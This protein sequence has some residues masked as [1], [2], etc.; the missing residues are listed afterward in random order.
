MNSN[1]NLEAAVGVLGFLGTGFCL[2]VASLLAVYSFARGKRERAANVL[3]ASFGGVALYLVLLLAFS[4]AS[5]EKQLARGEEKYFCEID[6]HLAY[7]VLNVRRTKTLGL[8]PDAI[9]AEGI[10]YVVTV[11]TRFDET[12]ITPRRGNFPL[13]PNSRVARVFDEEGRGYELAR[14]SG[15]PLTTPLRPGES[16]T[17]ELIFDLPADARNPRL[18]INETNFV[19]HFIVGHE[20]SPL[21]EKTEFR[22]EPSEGQSAGVAPTAQT[23]EES[24]LR[25][26]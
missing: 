9:S 18:L 24:A 3:L 5:R 6:C 26:R 25:R 15:T 23:R 7:S 2:F 1:V 8:A 20:N 17:T 4:L 22:L 13:T 14:T 11:R 10:F 21:H 16:Y 12:T 19:T